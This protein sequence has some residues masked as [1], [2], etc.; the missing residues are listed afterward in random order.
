MNVLN[1]SVL[2][3]NKFWQS[4]ET[5]TVK[6]AFC[7]VFSDRAR[8]INPEDNSEHDFVS[9]AELK[10]KEN[11]PYV[12]TGYLNLRLPE[13]IVLTSDHHMRTK[14]KVTF[15]KRNLMKRDNYTCAYC[16]KR[17]DSS[18]LT[19]DHIIPRS[20]GKEGRSSWMN[21]VMA[22]WGCNQKKDNRT[23]EE[24]GIKL[25][26]KPYEPKWTPLFRLPAHKHK[27]SWKKFI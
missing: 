1:E 6:T 10:P 27:E 9:W 5:C 15:S 17:F 3:L 19:M 20:R 24:A 8:I 26:I 4:I 23:P 16:G 14:E 22:C 21:C 12:T 13:V 7:K 11:Q 2:V 25:L 18:E